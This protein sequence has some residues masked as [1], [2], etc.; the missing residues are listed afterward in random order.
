M[1]FAREIS[2]AHT[3]L[4]VPVSEVKEPSR[5][6][7]TEISLE[8]QALKHFVLQLLPKERLHTLKWR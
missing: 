8:V 6:H 3:S 5:Y 2:P 4:E 7:H 1:G